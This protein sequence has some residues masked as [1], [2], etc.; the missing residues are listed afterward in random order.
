MS[1]GG[2]EDD[3]RKRR[4]AVLA[5]GATIALS[6]GLL[7]GGGAAAADEGGRPF[8]VALDGLN[9]VPPA[10]DGVHTGSVSLTLNQG[11]GQVCWQFGP[12]TLPPGESLPFAGHI[13]RAP[14]GVNGPIV[15]PLFPVPEAGVT[16]PTSYPT[17]TTCVPA[18]EAIIKEIRHNAEGFYVNLHNPTHPGGVM[19]GQLAK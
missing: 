10:T 7:A 17:A 9:E 5:I 6:A 16:A 14:A 18:S 13:H 2:K 8:H 19:R 4:L 11:L 1:G 3:M 12:I 15:V